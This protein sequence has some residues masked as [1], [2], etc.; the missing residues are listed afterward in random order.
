M[1]S[2]QLSVRSHRKKKSPMI[3]P[4]ICITNI[5]VRIYYNKY[6][7]TYIYITNIYVR[8]MYT[9]NICIT[10][11]YISYICNIYIYIYI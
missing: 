6:I 8:T 5:Y 1:H 2:K 7:R 3:L 11:I 9:F 10:Y 4:Y